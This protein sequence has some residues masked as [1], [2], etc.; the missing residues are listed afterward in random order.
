SYKGRTLVY[1]ADLLPSV[2]HLPIP[3]IMAYDMFPLTSLQ[4]KKTFLQEAAAAD[5]ILYF[6]HDPVNECCSLQ[7][8]EKGVRHQDL[9]R[10]EDL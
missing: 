1:M 5:T 2:A 8:T 3:Y 10:L 7:G 6:E 9:F 4:E